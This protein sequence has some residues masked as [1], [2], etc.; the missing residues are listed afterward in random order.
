VH[1]ISKNSF[2]GGLRKLVKI[3]ILLFA[4]KGTV[5]S[6]EIEYGNTH[7]RIIPVDMEKG[8]QIKT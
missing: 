3:L 2:I 7:L 1:N 5:S 4:D 8:P 6:V